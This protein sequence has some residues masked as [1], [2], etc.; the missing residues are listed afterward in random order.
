M[1]ACPSSTLIALFNGITFFYRTPN[2]HHVLPQSFTLLFFDDAYHKRSACFLGGV[3]ALEMNGP[4]LIFYLESISVCTAPD[5]FEK[6]CERPA[7]LD[8]CY[9]TEEA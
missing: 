6:Y 8:A 1:L 5:I 4:K 3:L 9:C 2:V 7:A